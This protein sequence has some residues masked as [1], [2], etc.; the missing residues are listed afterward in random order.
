MLR[1][2]AGLT[3]EET[4]EVLEVPLRTAERK[5]RFIRSWLREEL[6]IIL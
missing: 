5:W 4:A 2:F 3:M 1:Y 6:D